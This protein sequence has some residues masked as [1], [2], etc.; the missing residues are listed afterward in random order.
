MGEMNVPAWR[1]SSRC[2]TST[3]VEVA[4]VDDQYLVRDS[5]NPDAATLSFTKAEWDA[6]V[7][8]VTAGEF[9]F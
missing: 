5:K 6:F 2:G 1:K 3:C 7:E 9:R 8:G 4:K